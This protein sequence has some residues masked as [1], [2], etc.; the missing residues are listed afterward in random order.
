M[1]RRVV[2]IVIV[3]NL[4]IAARGQAI[5]RQVLDQVK[6]AV[7]FVKLKAGQLQGS[8]SGVVIKA[9]GDTVLVMTNRHVAAPEAGELPDGAK[10]ELSVVFRSGTAQQQ[11]LPALVLAYDERK[12]C[13]LAVLEVKGVRMPP[14]PIPAEQTTTE[15]EFIETMPVYAL[16]FPLGSRIQAVV[17]NRRV[18]NPAITVTPMSISSLR[19]D[20]SDRLAR[21]QLSGSLIEGN[22]GGPIVDAKGRLVGIAVSRVRGESVGF[23]I[24]PSVIAG[25]LG[26]DIGSLTAELLAAQGS[27]A[28]VKLSVR[29]V[30]PLGKLRGVAVRYAPQPASPVAAQRD[31]RGEWPVLPGGTSVPLSLAGGTANGQISLTVAKPDDRKLLMQFLLTDTAG[32]VAASKPTAV[33]LPDRPGI[34]PG[35]LEPSRPRTLA[36]WSS[37][38]NLA[39]GA[40]IT[41]QPGKTMIEIPGGIPMVNSPQFKLFNA[42]CALV[43]VDGDFIAVV[44]V[45]NDFDPGGEVVTMPGGKKMPFTFQG[46]GLLIWQDEKNFVRLERCKGSDGQVGLIHR[47]LVEIY[48]GGR[49]IG[50]HYSKPLPEQTM[51]LGAQRKGST[52][53]LLFAEG[54][55]R[56]HV[57]QELALDFEK[58]IFVGVSASNLS[59]LPLQAKFEDFAV[60]GLDG[61]EVEAKPVSMSRLIDTGVDHRPDGTWVLEGSL[62]KVL[63]AMGG[64]ASPQANMEQFKGQWSNNRQLLWR[65]A[66]V[67]DGL[68]LEIPIETAGNY[69]IKGQFTLGPEYA[70]LKFTLDGKALNQGKPADLYDK[71]LKPGPMMS[72]GTLNLVKG[73]HRF[74]AMIVG[75]NA[76]SGG[77]CFGVD[78]IQLI[79]APA[80]AAPKDAGRPKS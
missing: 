43:Q 28:Q 59:R 73:K 62:L 5:D 20:E 37:E 30:D 67:G 49:E 60:K 68:S 54:P 42:P 63:Q 47:I 44:K 34:I 26:G 70:K 11:E 13:D 24:P 66:K 36:K 14:R 16:G 7:V 41:H 21:V 52:V 75:K 74:T 79:P 32:R 1:K 17:D 65:A 23:A 40:K 33:N 15:S 29:M 6:D 53:Q 55:D 77:F 4:A 72:L 2:A 80:A 51:I 48:K 12:I 39:E 38:V 64:P 8:G 10:V 57:F 71:D 31:A 22:S 61:R 45:T 35:L 50:I 25:F 27:N 56:L 19:R 78:E 69:E 3:M 9:T 46:A 58:E 76:S 18:E